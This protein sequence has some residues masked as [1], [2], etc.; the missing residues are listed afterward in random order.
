MATA[1]IVLDTRRADKSANYPLKIRITHKGGNVAISTGV[2]I[3]SEAWELGKNGMEIKRG[4]PNAKTLNLELSSVLVKIQQGIKTLADSGKIEAMTASQIK[5]YVL[6]RSEKQ[7]ERV[8]FISYFREFVKTR[9]A[10]RTQE[11]YQNTLNKVVKWSND[12]VMFEDI[13]V[14]WLNDFHNH[15]KKE[16]NKLNTISIDERNI[17]AVIKSA[18]DEE[19]TDIKD[20]FRKYKIKQQEISDTMPLTIEQ[21]KAIRDFQPNSKAV[22]YARDVFM[23]SFYLIGINISDLYDLRKDLRARY[24]RHKTGAFVDIEIQP[25]AKELIDKY[26]DNERMFNFYKRYTSVESFRGQINKFLKEIGKSIGVPNLIMYHA[27]HSW[28]TLAAMQ[29]IEEKT[30]AKALS[31]SYKNTTS[32][33]A[34]FDFRKVDEANRKVLDLLL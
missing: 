34:R 6:N 3:P 18:M 21:V 9:N 20:P 22:A 14:S 17:R 19:V 15:L 11:L 25:E 12:Y 29:D 31:H 16:G 4:Y 24:Y 32:R 1:A 2:N 28:A 13:T 8:T 33:Y 7:A 5:D 27:R 23:A 30:I 10:K 26:S